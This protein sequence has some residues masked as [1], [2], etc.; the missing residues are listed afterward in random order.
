MC[1]PPISR[2][3][4]ICYFVIISIANRILVYNEGLEAMPAEIATAL[5]ND[6]TLEVVGNKVEEVTRPFRIFRHGVL[7]IFIIGWAI[8]FLWFM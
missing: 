1:P 4:P 2:N 7:P 6:E 8:Y 3:Q 5:L